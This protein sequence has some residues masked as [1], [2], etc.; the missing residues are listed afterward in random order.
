MSSSGRGL[1]YR[2]AAEE[3]AM[4]DGLRSAE[5]FAVAAADLG[6]DQAAARQM[7][8]GI[9]EK[10]RLIS[11][12][13]NR[14]SE[15]A[16]EVPAR[17]PCPY[18]ENYAGRHGPHGPPAVVAE[19]EIISVFLAPA[20]LGGMPGHV[21]VATRRHVETIFDLIPAEETA[22]GRAIAA[23]ARAVRAAFDPAGVLVQQ[24]N[25]IAAF[26]TVPHVHFH[27]VPKSP[28]PF[29]PA[30][31]AQVIPFEVRARQ[32]DEIRQHWALGRS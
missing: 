24:H 7:L 20:A 23:A 4:L 32:A 6:L 28:G 12:D 14:G 25:G 16:F 17:D 26:Q 15:G 19:D 9:A 1:A 10:L 31:P 5:D 29:P 3:W 18:C 13:G 30:E 22:M 11:L 21:L 27:V 8:A 2:L